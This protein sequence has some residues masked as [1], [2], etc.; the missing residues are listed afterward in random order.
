MSKR[1]YW[2][3]GALA[4]V[5]VILRQ[6]LL[7]LISIILALVAGASA[8][9]TRYCLVAVTYRRHF[10]STRL[11]FG[12]TTD[13]RVEITNAKPLPLAWLRIDDSLPAALPLLSLQ[14]EEDELGER[15]QLVNVLSLR[16]YERVTRRY[17]VQAAQRGVWSFGP[18]QLRS[19]DLFGF[20]VQRAMI[21]EIDS[22]VVFPR[23]VPVTALGLPARY[24]FGD[25]RTSRR[26]VEDPL[27]LMGVR[28]YAQGD[29][30]RHIHW[31][32]TARR[33]TLQTKVFEPSANRPVL[34]F[35][36]ISTAEFYYQG[37]DAELS[38]YAITAA[39]SLARQ[40]WQDGQPVGLICNAHAPRTSRYI[41]V[42]PGNHPSQ[43]VQIL[44]ALAQINE[45]HGRWPIETL[46][47]AEARRLPP[48]TTIVVISPVVSKLL[49]Q[50]LVD[51]RR[52]EYGVALVALGKARLSTPLLGVQYVHIGG[53]ERWHDLVSSTAAAL[54][55]A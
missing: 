46:L 21:E 32:A 38:E 49:E 20:N 13:L 22:L 5:S 27:R 4:L 48:G 51:L 23:L 45:G 41:R 11:Y 25:F 37:F 36:N 34:I 2:I 16:W 55:L 40:I 14:L 8:L 47:Q 39:A 3:I 33:Q 50:T 15:R 28:E 18:A 44:T 19:G 52:R 1:W 30:F 6:E 9:W 24:P 10:G 43:L 29:N 31:K 35:L 17:R 26:S 42:Q 54:E 7:F 12:E 53:K